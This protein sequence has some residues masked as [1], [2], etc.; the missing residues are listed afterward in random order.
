MPIH[1]EPDHRR[2]SDTAL[3]AA[4]GARDPLALAEAYHRTGPA[5]HACARRL[6]GSPAEAEAVLRGVYAQL[7]AEPPSDGPLEGWVRGRAHA[8]GVARLASTGRPAAAPSTAELV[9][10]LGAPSS[11]RRP[12]PVEEVLGRLDDRDRRALV[13]AH[14]HGVPSGRQGA[15]A[16]RALVRA[17]LAVAGPDDTVPAGVCDDVDGLADWV[18]GLVAEDRAAVLHA[19]VAARPDCAERVRALRRG[20]RRMEGLPP[21]AD[22]GQRVLVAVVAG[23][24]VDRDRAAVTA[25]APPREDSAPDAT[26]QVVRTARRPER[27][28]GR[29]SPAGPPPAGPP[30]AGPSPEPDT[31]TATDA[32]VVPSAARRAAAPAPADHDAP[33]L[34]AARAPADRDAPAPAPAV[35]AAQDGAADP[36]APRRAVLVDGA[37]GGG[38]PTGRRTSGGAHTPVA[39][40]DAAWAPPGPLAAPAPDPPNPVEPEPLD[41]SDGGRGA[42]V[43]DDLHEDDIGWRDDDSHDDDRDERSSSV[44]STVLTIV[45]ALLSIGVGFVVVSALLSAL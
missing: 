13:L 22:A 1:D 12:E 24:P 44:R 39:D 37:D 43:V 42:T 45:I 33:S 9:P 34:A 17:L 20:R 11:H 3:I 38:G 26:V 8:L 19:Q 15:G 10:E 27:G 32:V 7:W 5:A 29:T 18:L 25:P 21:T 28:P 16:D 36:P 30:P 35:R 4:I 6:L 23:L 31:G 41:R 2:A 40:P 14:D